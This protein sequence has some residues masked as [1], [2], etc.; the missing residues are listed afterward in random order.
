MKRN[1]L[2]PLTCL[3]MNLS[4]IVQAATYHVDSVGGND[5]NDG[6]TP[7]AAWRSLAKANTTTFQP[8]DRLLLKSGSV[9]T[10]QLH[11]RGSGS[12]TN[13]I[14]LDC[15]G[16][17]PKPI[18]HG[19]GIAGGAVLLENQQYWSIRNMEVSNQGSAAAKKMAGE[20]QS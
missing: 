1:T 18:I 11:P 16:E 3:L 15:Y 6:R 20:L 17:G 8:G 13:W 9:W 14:V 19:G 12:A 10:G 5:A 7:A 4:V 2:L